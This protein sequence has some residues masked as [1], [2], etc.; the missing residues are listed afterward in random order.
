M[1]VRITKRANREIGDFAP[2]KKNLKVISKILRSTAV[3]LGL[4][5]SAAAKFN[6]LKSAE[7]SPD[8]K[9]G[10][11]GF[12]REISEVR[13]AY[14]DVCDKLSD[15]YDCLYDECK[16][17]HWN[18]KEIEKEIEEEVEETKEFINNSEN[19][20]FLIDKVDKELHPEKY[21]EDEKEDEGEEDTESEKDKKEK[22]EQH[23]G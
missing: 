5:N 7:I 14:F 10:G 11:K 17:P 1:R 13:K 16:A 15:I 21:A 23:I 20:E 12:V 2:N 9:L 3:G 19:S 4:V 6:Q 8:G 18:D 22:F